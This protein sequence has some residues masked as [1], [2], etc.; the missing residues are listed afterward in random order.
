M[1]PAAD[2]GFLPEDDFDIVEAAV[3]KRAA[4]DRRSSAAFAWLG[5]RQIDEAVLGEIRIERNVE[6]TALAIVNY[7]G[8]AFDRLGDRAV[9]RDDP[10]TSGLLGHK[11]SS[12]GQKSKT[13]KLV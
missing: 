6:K 11:H 5:I 3:T 2:L 4:C 9:H 12:V 7:L 13:P 1:V 8:Y 10:Q